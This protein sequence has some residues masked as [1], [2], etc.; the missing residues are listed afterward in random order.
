MNYTTYL[1]DFDYTLADSS[2]GIVTCFQIVLKR[3]G[4]TEITDEAIKRT[5]GKTLED[6]FSILTGITD[7]EQLAGLRKEYSTEAGT[8]MNPNTFL[9]PDTIRALQK[10]KAQGMKLGIIST[11]YRY[12]IQSFLDEKAP[13]DWFS[14][15]VGGEDVSSHKPNPEGLLYAIDK[16]GVSPEAVIYV[17]D[18]IV[19]AETAQAA[20]VTFVGVTHGVTTADE[21]SQYPHLRIINTLEDLPGNDSQTTVKEKK[22]KIGIAPIILLSFLLFLTLAELIAGGTYFFLIILLLTFWKISQ[23]RQILPSGLKAVIIRWCRPFIVYIRALHIWQIKGVKTCPATTETTVCKNCGNIY[24][25]NFCNRCGQSCNTPRFRL[26]NAFK[27]ALGGLSNIDTGFGRTLVELLYRPGYMIKDFIAGKRVHYFRPFQTLFVLAAL[28]ILAVELIDP[29]SLKKSKEDP[30]TVETEQFIAAR[31][32]LQQQMDTTQDVHKREAL[33]QIVN[34]LDRHIKKN[35]KENLALDEVIAQGISEQDNP[36][37][38]IVNTRKE[39]SEHIRQRIDNMPFLKKVY[40]LL[41]SWTHGNKAVSIIC[42]LPVF[43]F[44]TRMTFRRRKY[45]HDY[46]MTEQIFIQTYIACQ[47][48]LISILILPFNGKAAVN[49]LYDIPWWCI[50]LLFLWDYRQLFNCNWYRSFWR[51]V[52]MFVYSYLIIMTIAILAVA[53]LIPGIYLLKAIGI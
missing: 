16:L 34:K 20:G 2:R 33:S 25:G 35:K 19:D 51:T 31:T 44:A 24:T 7:A 18:S 22:K 13:Y 11:K 29:A 23:K 27:S 10:L 30:Q 14:I 12:R 5:I 43:A 48:L 1:F 40:N 46:N 21:L 45:N 8:Y 15:I 37:K 17:G 50:F 6:S 28:Y 41:D 39:I 49:D 3:H 53:I 9:F 4:Y 47:I 38:D 26:R 52:L 42:T 36:I 32:L